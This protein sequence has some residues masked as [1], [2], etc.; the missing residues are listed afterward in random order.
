MRTFGK[1]DF[2][3]FEYISDDYLGTP[4]SSSYS[5]ISYR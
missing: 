5:Y 3:N 2:K 4:Y 1:N